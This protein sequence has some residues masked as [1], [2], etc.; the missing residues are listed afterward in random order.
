MESNINMHTDFPKLFSEISSDGDGRSKRWVGVEAFSV[1][2]TKDR[3]EMLVRLAFDTKPPAE[4]HQQ[5]EL[6]NE[7]AAFHKAFSDADPSYEQ[8]KRQS[9]ILAAAVLMQHF[10]MTSKA[11]MAVITTSCDGARKVALPVDLVTEAENTLS[12]HSANRRR[13]P[14][15]DELTINAP[16]LEYELDFD[17]VQPSQPETFKGVLDQLSGAI[18]E[19][20][21]AVINKSNASIKALVNASKQADEELDML[22]WVFGEK[23]LLPNQ[24]FSD[25]PADQMPLLFARDL[26][27]LTTVHPGPNS[28][29]ALLARAGIGSMGTLSIADAVNAVTDEW[30]AEVLTNKKPSPAT[31]PIHFA[32]AK[33][34][35]TGAGDSWHAGW[36]AITGIEIDASMPPLV[37]AK[38]FYHETLWLG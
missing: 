18:E 26:A 16:Q 2:S 4:G 25:T 24:S 38:H 21:T 20:F 31:T 3:I 6:A 37:L 9:Q 36:A 28:A 14:K 34:Q 27:S 35:E 33:R 8:G 19:A 10:S 32:L 7:L 12:K 15:L 30:T 23:A 13:R 5:E 29:P 22:S 17:E 1:G 11:A